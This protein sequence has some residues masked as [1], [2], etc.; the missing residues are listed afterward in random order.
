MA[1]QNAQVQYSK[2]QGSRR[3]PADN[4]RN[5]SRTE[6]TSETF[7]RRTYDE[8]NPLAESIDRK[9][10]AAKAQ[11]QDTTAQIINKNVETSRQLPTITKRPIKKAV[12]ASD[13]TI[14]KV[15]SRFLTAALLGFWSFQLAGW[16]LMVFG[17]GAAAGGAALLSWLPL[18]GSYGTDIS[19]AVGLSIS[20]A[21]WL[22]VVLI[23]IGSVLICH[24][25]RSALKKQS[26][27]A[28]VMVSTLYLAPIINIAPWFI[29]YLWVTKR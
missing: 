6:S 10:A 3:V 23:G 13:R 12:K 29:L 1:T 11:K 19:I 16:F 25:A 14:T 28:L 2:K 24:F 20:F 8:R 4:R 18:I 21:G 22:L 26:T 9:Q 7:T 15:T 17:I 27:A 5:R